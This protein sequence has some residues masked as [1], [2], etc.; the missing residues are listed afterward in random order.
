[1]S[2][3]NAHSHDSARFGQGTVIRRALDIGA[4]SYQGGIAERGSG[5][6]ADSLLTAQFLDELVERVADRI[7]ERVIVELERRGRRSMP[8]VF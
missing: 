2:A 1:M 5:P 8:E 6:D 3:P 7:E 4:D